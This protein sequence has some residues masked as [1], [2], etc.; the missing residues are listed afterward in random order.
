MNARTILGVVV[1]AI[2]ILAGYFFWPSQKTQDAEPVTDDLV[3]ANN[4]AEIGVAHTFEGGVHTISGE[5]T[6]PNPCYELQEDV[7]I[8]ESFP[9]QVFIELT[10]VASDGICIQITDTRPFS[11]DVEVDEQASFTL[12]VNGEDVPVP[13]IA[14]Q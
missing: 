7:A 4:E 14:V 3:V 2:I 9:E 5:I 6:L 10:G 1:V 8:A 11:I 13:S 12:S